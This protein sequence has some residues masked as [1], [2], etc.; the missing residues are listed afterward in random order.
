MGFRATVCVS[1]CLDGKL[2]E[3]LRV[4]SEAEDNTGFSFLQTGIE[5]VSDWNET[6]KLLIVE[7]HKL[8]ARPPIIL[9]DSNC[10]SAGEP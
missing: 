8:S 5:I 6:L 1:A 4:R 2:D 10:T 7:G 9:F 3:G